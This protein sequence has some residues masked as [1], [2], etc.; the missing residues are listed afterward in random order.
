MRSFE[1]SKYEVIQELWEAVMGKNPSRFGN[2]PR[3]PVETVN[4]A[5]IK[6]FLKELNALTGERYRLPTEA[7]WEYAA[8]GG[9]QSRGYKYAGSNEPDSVAWYEG[10]SGKR[11]HPIGQKAPNELGL[12]DMSGNVWEWVEDCWNESYAGAPADGSASRSGY[13]FAHVVRGGSWYDLPRN[14]RAAFRG[15]YVAGVRDNRRGFRVVRTLTDSAAMLPAADQQHEDELVQRVFESIQKWEFKSSIEIENPDLQSSGC[16]DTSVTDSSGRS[17]K[18]IADQWGYDPEEAYAFGLKIQDAVRKR[19]LP[20]FFSL[21][22]G[23]LD[24]GPRRKYVEN[25]AFHEVFPDSW[26]A[27]ILKDE[28]PCTPFG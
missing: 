16:A 15:W 22:D 11:P 7:E 19:D 17:L 27:A 28:P 21:V 6:T 1:I 13:C 23:E 12:Y 10:N 20:K 14:L 9:Q 26:R 5:D 25:K 18:D 3:C 8:R 4:W 2:C 24:Y